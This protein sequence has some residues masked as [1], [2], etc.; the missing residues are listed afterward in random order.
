[1]IFV[2]MAAHDTSTITLTTMAYYL[3]KHPEWQDRARAQSRSL[4]REIN[5]DNLDE[6][7]A[8]DAVMKES[9]R[10]NS[11]VPGLARRALEDT[12]SNG[13]FVPKGTYVSA[14]GMVTHHNPDLW[15]HP[16]RFDPDRTPPAP[17]E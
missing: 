9:L 11:P 5:Y 7:T 14:A 15:T 12:E 13:H 17:A 10:L 4:P 16:E 3:A 2:L 6:F 1:M 8:L